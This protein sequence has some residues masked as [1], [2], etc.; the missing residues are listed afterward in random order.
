MAVIFA[1]HEHDDALLLSE[2]MAVMNA[3]RVLQTGRTEDVVN[4]PSDP[5]VASFLGTETI[6]PGRVMA[7]EDDCLRVSVGKIEIEAIGDATVGD[8]VTLCIRPESVTLSTAATN[9]ASSARNT[10]A[11][12]ILQVVPRR[13]Y[14]RVELDA[15][16]FL[17]AHVT[18]KSLEEM[19]LAE[20]R[21]VTVSFKAT[22]VHVIP[23]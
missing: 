6:L 4:H 2:E 22:A 16:C 5:F 12:K 1:T 19:N 3:G 7:V 20:N 13:H 21:P 15:G 9:A 10:F 8:S 14:H 17:V 18:M 11:A 23:R